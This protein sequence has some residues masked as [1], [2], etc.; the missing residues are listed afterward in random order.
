MLSLFQV[1]IIFLYFLLSL[2]PGCVCLKRL[3]PF[4]QLLSSLYRCLCCPQE[5][6]NLPSLL[7]LTAMGKPCCILAFLRIQSEERKTFPSGINIL[8]WQVGARMS[9]LCSGK[10]FQEYLVFK[11]RGAHSLKE[12]LCRTT[13]NSSKGSFLRL[14]FKAVLQMSFIIFACLCFHLCIHIY[15]L[16][17]H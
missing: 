3:S 9:P 14:Y 11:H 7:S 16:H 4:L 15:Y 17:S 6:L 12:S 10:W 1:L 13:H 8:P 5:F 2:F